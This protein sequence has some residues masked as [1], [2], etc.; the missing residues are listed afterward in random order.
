[1]RLR[2][3]RCVSSNRLRGQ[4]SVEYLFVLVFLV[5]FIVA[6][7]VP[8][9]RE[10]EISVA[11]SAARQGFLDA[12]PG[13]ARLLALNYSVQEETVWLD[14]RA[15]NRSTGGA[16][17]LSPELRVGVLDGIQRLS[18]GQARND[19]CAFT[20]NFNYCLVVES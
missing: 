17:V 3:T 20:S 7:L 16:L 5:G 6:V 15:V 1:M 19:S 8:S 12:A 2:V 10:A 4:G 13:D 9:V 14:P 11:L 18:P